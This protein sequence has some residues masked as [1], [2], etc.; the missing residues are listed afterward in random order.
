MKPGRCPRGMEG[1]VG[2]VR[3]SK[4]ADPCALD[5]VVIRSGHCATARLHS[6]E[7]TCLEEK[8]RRLLPE[9]ARR[10]RI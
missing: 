8:S 2:S 1:V 3:K 9:T 6:P 5:E 10:A 4:E 7:A